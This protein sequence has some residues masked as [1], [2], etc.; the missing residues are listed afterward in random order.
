MASAAKNAVVLGVFTAR[1]EAAPFPNKIHAL[2][3]QNQP[4]VYL[5]TRLSSLPGT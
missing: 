5:I 4:A 3:K 1:L 2:S